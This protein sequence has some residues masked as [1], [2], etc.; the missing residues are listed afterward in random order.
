MITARNANEKVVLDFFAGLNGNDPDAVRAQ[1]APDVHWRPM[2]T[3]VA[4]YTIDTIF[5]ELLPYLQSIFVDGDPQQTVKSVV[6]SDDVV[7]VETLASGAVPS[8]EDR[9]ENDY[10]WVL[11]LKNGKIATIREYLDIDKIRAFFA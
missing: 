9:Y 2:V 4:G 8:K 3:G 1:L 6:S 11:E 5:T 7:V 10:C